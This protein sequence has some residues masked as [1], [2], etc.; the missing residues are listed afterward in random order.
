MPEKA[1]KEV[2]A[3]YHLTAEQAAALFGLLDQGYGIPYLMRYRKEVAGGLSASEFYELIEERK[4]LAKLDLRRR[5]ILKKLKERDI[6]PDE[7]AEKI[8]QA[9]DM[10]ELIDHYVPYRPRKRS[11]SRQ[12]LAQ[13][14]EKLA[15]AVLSQEELIPQMGAAAEPYIDAAKGLNDVGAV[16]EGVFHIVCDWIAEEKTHRERQRNVFAENAE[17]VSTRAAR[18]IPEIGR[19]H[20]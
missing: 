13:G 18:V 14:L 7:L 9:R 8:M 5:K 3:K 1:L 12:A 20:V 2:A 11:R 10:Q 17:L 4:R 16:L 19:A 6:L 15:V